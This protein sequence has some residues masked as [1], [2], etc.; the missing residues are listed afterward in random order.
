MSRY[1]VMVCCVPF[2]RTT[3]AQPGKAFEGRGM[4]RV[5]K[6]SNH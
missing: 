3:I 1:R 6:K 4:E 5:K 2:A